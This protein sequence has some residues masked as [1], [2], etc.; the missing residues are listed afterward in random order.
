LNNTELYLAHIDALHNPAHK[1]TAM[2]TCELQ[3]ARAGAATAL[4][5][6]PIL[7]ADGGA[8][9]R[10][11]AL[12]DGVA[13]GVSGM[14]PATVAAIPQLRGRLPETSFPRAEHVARCL[15]TLPTHPFV[16]AADRARLCELVNEMLHHRQD[17]RKVS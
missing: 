13:L 14:Y 2:A 5:R 8:K 12:R 4:L 17:E 15:V 1:V 16:T 9:E 11:L 10:L 3:P 7:L 6:F